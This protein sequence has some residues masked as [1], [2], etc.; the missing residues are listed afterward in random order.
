MI[1][2][3]TWTSWNPFDA[4]PPETEHCWV[5][6][7]VEESQLLPLFASNQE[8]SVHHFN[9]SWKIVEPQGRSDLKKQIS[10]WKVNASA[11]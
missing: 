7:N 11:I 1:F 5:M 9:E 4:D 6:I 10:N 8:N 3:D 2:D